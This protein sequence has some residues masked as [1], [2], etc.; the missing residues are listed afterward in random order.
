MLIFGFP[1]LIP[2][3][4]LCPP[5]LAESG[6]STYLADDIL[7][8]QNVVADEAI[9]GPTHPCPILRTPRLVSPTQ[10]A[11]RPMVLEG[12]AGVLCVP[13]WGEDTVKNHSWAYSELLPPAFSVL[14][15]KTILSTSSCTLGFKG[16]T[17]PLWGIPLHFPTPCLIAQLLGPLL[18]QYK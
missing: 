7:R 17:S 3:T 10:S 6:L 2:T 15:L 12:V 8:Q 18:S 9:S 4:N 1:S 14:F 16:L 11:E 5:G 13:K